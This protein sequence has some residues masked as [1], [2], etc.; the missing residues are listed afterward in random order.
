MD[1]LVSEEEARGLRRV[2]CR[3]PVQRKI[4]Q[5]GRHVGAGAFDVD[6][7]DH[8]RAVGVDALSLVDGEGD[9]GVDAAQVRKGT[10]HMPLADVAAAVAGCRELLKEGD[11]RRIPRRQIVDD[12][13]APRVL[14]GDE[15]GSRWTA[16]S[17][18][19]GRIREAHTLRGHAIEV[20]RLQSGSHPGEPEVVGP[21][22]VTEDDDE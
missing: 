20:G 9:E 21:M 5:V 19:D 2:A 14:S 12:P 15:T 8:Q 7:V 13:V 6:A 4:G 3:E 18:R 17:R 1:R 22:V 16:Q 11:I 10:G